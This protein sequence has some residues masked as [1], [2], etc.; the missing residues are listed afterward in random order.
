MM[1]RFRLPSSSSSSSPC[2]SSSS[3]IVGSGGEIEVLPE[4]V[5]PILQPEPRPKRPRTKRNKIL[6]AHSPTSGSTGRSSV[7]RGVTRHRWTG[8]YEAHL[9]DKSIW[10]S[11]QNKR[12]RQTYLGA[13]ESEEAAARTYDLAALKYWG[14]VTTL[15][16]PIETYSKEL[17]E[18]EK[19]SREEFLASLR[20]RSSGFS[21]GVSKYRGVAR[22]HHNGRWEA[23]IGRVSGNKYLYLGTF[24]TQEEAATAYDMAAI[25][26]RGSNAVTNFDISV[27]ADKLKEIRERNER[28]QQGNDESSCEVQSNAQEEHKEESQKWNE[29]EKYFV[30]EI[31]PMLEDARSNSE[32]RMEHPKIPKLEFAPSPSSPMITAIDPLEEPESF[33][34]SPCMDAGHDSFPVHDLHLDEKP[35]YLLDFFNDSSIGNSLDFLFEE[36]SSGNEFG[37]SDI[38]GSTTLISDEFEAAMVNEG[39]NAAFTAPSPSSNSTT[40]SVYAEISAASKLLNC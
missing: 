5:K 29:E 27:Y 9:W 20:R 33:W 19:L 13:Y 31:V 14:P 32:G 6:N 23:R 25:E 11:T 8:R 38:C 30:E 2:S 39:H 24:S 16:F 12:G 4:P 3:C 1:K 37:C 35:S 34:N 7:Y 18:M 22:H 10:N 40:L 28:E 26:Y 15:N 17:E 21:R 36:P